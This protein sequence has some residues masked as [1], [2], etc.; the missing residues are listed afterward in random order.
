MVYTTERFTDNSPMSPGTFL[1]FKN[2]S[3]RK[4]IRTFTEI[5]NIKNK[6]AVSW[7]CAAKLNL[8]EIISC[9]ILW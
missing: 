1:T 7:V 6:T 8:K 4:S 3:A 9:S 5:L 2:T